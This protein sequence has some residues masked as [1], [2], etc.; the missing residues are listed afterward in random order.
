MEINPY[1]WNQLIFNKDDKETQQWNDNFLTNGTGTT[2]ILT[3]KKIRT[4][5]VTSYFIQLFLIFTTPIKVML[6]SSKKFLGFS[7][8]ILGPWTI[9][10]LCRVWSKDLS[11]S[12]KFKYFD[13]QK[14]PKLKKWKWGLEVWFKQ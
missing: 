1:I 14:N 4:Q 3:C 5:I 7:F 9:L 10:F 6:L 2:W 8:Y 11:S 13:L 12:S